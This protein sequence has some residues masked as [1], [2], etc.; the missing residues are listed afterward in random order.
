MDDY[1]VM[2]KNQNGKCAICQIPQSSLKYALCVDHCHETDR[3]RGLLCDKCNM[4]L[5]I[6]ND[7]VTILEEARKYLITNS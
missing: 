2:L 7:D 4:G 5:G 3:I 1:N 6:F